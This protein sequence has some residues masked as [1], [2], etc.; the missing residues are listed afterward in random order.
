MRVV[1]LPAFNSKELNSYNWYLYK[2]IEALGQPVEEFHWQMMLRP[3]TPDIF[4]IH[5][6]ELEVLTPRSSA[7][8]MIRFL[9]FWLYLH[10]V[11]RRGGKIVWTAH[12]AFGH[13]QRQSRLNLKLWSRFLTLVGA[14]IYLS[15][16]S[17]RII[18]SAHPKLSAKPSAV[19][20]HGHYI[21]WLREAE[22]SVAPSALSRSALGIP[23]DAKVI[24]NFGLIRPYKGTLPLIAEFKA[25]PRENVHLVIA[26]EA[27]DEQL[28]RSILES[29][30]GD[31]RI[32][33]VLKRLEGADLAA[34]LEFCDLIVL[35]YLKITNSGSAILALSAGRRVLAPRL[36]SLPELQTLVGR[37]WLLL[38]DGSI[39]RQHLLDAV[40]WT[41][42]PTAPLNMQPF[43]WDSVASQTLRLYRSLDGGG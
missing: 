3:N 37:E 19:I 32:H 23:S 12:N 34:L 8:R 29:A 41:E 11:R 39:S 22:H 5:W 9:L 43:D 16:E 1:A 40:A 2:N 15:E 24:A 25:T 7:R 20:Q 36:G 35:P 27:S 42:T 21:D 38:Y 4:H 14:V 33:C 13:D 31:P 17:K 26:G 6:P 10:A 28:E 18:E 30:A